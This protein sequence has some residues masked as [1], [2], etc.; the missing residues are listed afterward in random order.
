M[1]LAKMGFLMHD[2][3]IGAVLS[4]FFKCFNLNN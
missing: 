3:M 4:V 2:S 1:N